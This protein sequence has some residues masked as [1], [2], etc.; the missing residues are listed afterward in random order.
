MDAWLCERARQFIMVSMAAKPPHHIWYYF[1]IYGGE[2][3]IIWLLWYYFVVFMA[4]KPPHRFILDYYG[5]C[6][7]DADVF[8]MV[9]I[10]AKPLHHIIYFAIYGGEAASYMYIMYLFWYLN[11]IYGGEAALLY[12]NG[13]YGGEAALLYLFWYLYGIYGGEAASSYLLWYLWRCAASSAQYR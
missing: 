1:G 6:G 13:I 9:F 8:I 3:L 5:I 10:A 11:G 12:L 4:A 2:R 7:G